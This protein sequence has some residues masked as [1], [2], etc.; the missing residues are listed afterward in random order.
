MKQDKDEKRHQTLKKD[1]DMQAIELLV[2]EIP[3]IYMFT[4]ALV[5]IFLALVFSILYF[6]KRDQYDVLEKKHDTLTIRFMPVISAEEE[7][8]KIQAAINKREAACRLMEIESQEEHNRLKQDYRVKRA[9]YES[10]LRQVSILEEDL[11]FISFGVYKPHFEFDSSE[12][13]KQEIKNN[14]EFQKQIIRSKAA[15]VCSTEWEV[16]GSK[17]EGTKMTNRNIK[18]MLRAFNGE[19]DA[20][21]LKV[22]WNNAVKMEERIIKSFEAINKLGETIQ[23]YITREYL[24]AKL[25]ELYL[26]HENQ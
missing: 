19:C 13:Y 9:L 25:N 21:I 16:G 22:K 11:E 4:S 24:S 8:A 12:R 14:K 23:T 18:L 7:A 17:R 26:T 1:I 2:A 15:C 6:K 5:G 3:S 10:L 20:A